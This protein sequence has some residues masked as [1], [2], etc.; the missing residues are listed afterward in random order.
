MIFV[1]KIKVM[2][3]K[4]YSIVRSWIKTDFKPPQYSLKY[5]NIKNCKLIPNRN[6]L[7][8][9]LPKE[10][11]VAEVGVYRGDYSEKI[12]NTC[13]PSKL[14]LIDLFPDNTMDIVYDKFCRQINLGTIELHASDSVETSFPDRYFDWIYIDTEHK[15]DRLIKELYHY[16]PTIRRGGFIAGHDFVIGNWNEFIKYGV[17]EAVNEFCV[18]NDWELIYLTMETHSSFVIRKI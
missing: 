7:L 17:I 5:R 1:I 2:R 12:W 9:K 4:L 14:H 11:I 15:Y 3:R 18:N 8:N 16:A 13:R 6:L 10:G